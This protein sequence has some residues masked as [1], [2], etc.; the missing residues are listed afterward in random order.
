[1]PRDG[2]AP[3]RA[4]VVNAL[5]NTSVA[6]TVIP[7]AGSPQPGTIGQ[8]ITASRTASSPFVRVRENRDSERRAPA[9]REAAPVIAALER[10]TVPARP[11]VDG[12]ARTDHG[13]DTETKR[14]ALQRELARLTAPGVLVA[15]ADDGRLVCRACAHGCRLRDGEVGLCRVRFRDGPALRVPFGYVAARRIMPVERN[16]IYHLRP[17]SLGLTFGMFGC[18]LH[19][20]WCS[21]ASISQAVRADDVDPPPVERVSAAA[22]VQQA[23]DAGCR[24]VVSAFNEPMITAEWAFAVFSEARARGLATAVVSDGNTTGEALAYLRPVTDVFRVDLKATRPQH[25]DLVGAV[26]DVPLHALREARRL[27][28]W[29]EAVSM[30]VPGV[31][32]DLDGLRALATELTAIDRDLPWHLNGFVPRYHMR[33]RPALSTRILVAAADV[34]YAAGLRY[35]YVGNVADRLSELSHTRCPGCYLPVIRRFNYTVR[36][37]CLRDG[38]CPRC[39]RVIPGRWESAT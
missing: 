34:A 33:D 37:Q 12:C 30:I 29:V 1:M 14:A 13:V 11:H 24:V 19:C 27:G 22:L 36:D 6:T 26:R 39:G 21:N 4:N 2:I 18:D 31:N 23:I 8:H 32:D 25:Y 17:G 16:T 20:P 15:T 5:V 9:H 10:G 3:R 7:S 35:V 38:R 28:Y